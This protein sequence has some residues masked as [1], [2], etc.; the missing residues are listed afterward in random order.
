MFTI[1]SAKEGDLLD[2][3]AWFEANNLPAQ[4]L[5]QI[6]PFSMLLRINDVLMGHITYAFTKE[7]ACMIT[8][9]FVAP[10][11]RHQKFGDTLMRSLMNLLSRR[12]F[13]VLYAQSDC[14][15]IPFLE[16]FGFQKDEDTALWVIPSIDAFFKKPCKGMNA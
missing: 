13:D 4:G 16:H 11:I 10:S 3:K 15:V 14:S 6:L 8:G 9:I 2:A 5:E 7:D 12:G 1:L